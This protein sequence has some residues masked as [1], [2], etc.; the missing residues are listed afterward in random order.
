MCLP[1]WQAVD[2]DEGRL[3]PVNSG[4]PVGLG[5]AC[6]SV[7]Y[8]SAQHLRVWMPSWQAV[9]T[10]EG[11]LVS[12]QGKRR[13][14]PDEAEEGLSETEGEQRPCRGNAP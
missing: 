4:M 6:A 1:S 10:D 13:A 2:T 3:T 11:D 9:D 5:T 7:I 8:C 12:Q 14:V